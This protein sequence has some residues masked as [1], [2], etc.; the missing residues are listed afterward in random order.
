VPG[1]AFGAPRH[2][3]LSYATSEAVLEEALAR[4]ERHLAARQSSR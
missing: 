2:L 3:R 4:L 1:S